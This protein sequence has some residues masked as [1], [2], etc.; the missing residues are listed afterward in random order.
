MDNKEHGIF[1]TKSSKQPHAIGLSTVKLLGVENNVIH[2]EMIDM[3]NGT[4]LIDINPF[5]SKLDNR[6][7]TK[8]GWLDVLEIIPFRD[9]HFDAR[10]K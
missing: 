9:R 3:L 10:F 1:A 5:F 2:I 8:S 6:T 4:P 7:Y